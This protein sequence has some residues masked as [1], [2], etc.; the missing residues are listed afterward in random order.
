MP[1]GDGTEPIGI[2]RG[3]GH[4][5]GQCGRGLRRGYLGNGG[6]MGYG[7]YFHISKEEELTILKN[8]QN[9]IEQKLDEVKKRIEEMEK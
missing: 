3:R 8:E 1:Y 6:G 2:K 5:R 7:R 9:I 4:G